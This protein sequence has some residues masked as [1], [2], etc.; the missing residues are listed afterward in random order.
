MI[1]YNKFQNKNKNNYKNCLEHTNIY[2][3]H[4][5]NTLKQLNI[6]YS[7]LYIYIYI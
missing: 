2:Y 6:Y 5:G 1:N 3:S 4:D 7:I